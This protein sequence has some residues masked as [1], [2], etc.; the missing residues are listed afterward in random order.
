MCCLSF[1]FEYQKFLEV[2]CVVDLASVNYVCYT[3]KHV[4]I[5]MIESNSLLFGRG[6]G[7]NEDHRILTVCEVFQT[8]SKFQ[9]VSSKLLYHLS[10]KLLKLPEVQSNYKERR[11]NILPYIF[12]QMTKNTLLTSLLKLSDMQT[13]KS[14]VYSSIDSIFLKLHD[15]KSQ[16]IVTPL[17]TSIVLCVSSI[18]PVNRDLTYMMNNTCHLHGTYALFMRSQQAHKQASPIVTMT[19][20]CM[21]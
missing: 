1:I 12:T 8:S 5:L 9:N 21:H 2:E 7:I 14:V 13:G 19:P 17:S 3:K 15:I 18:S 16:L 11:D 6:R 4:W 10:T 20:I